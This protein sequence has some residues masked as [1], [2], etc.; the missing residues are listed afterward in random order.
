MTMAGSS[1]R[2]V[3]APRHLLKKSQIA[4][5]EETAFQHRLN[6]NALRHT[7]SLGRA[8]GMTRLGVHLVRLEP[9]RDST[10]YHFHHHE[11][12]FVYI[13]SGRGE[14]DIGEETHPVEAGDFMGFSAPSLPHIMRNPHDEDLVYL[15]GGQS[16]AD[17]VTE[18]PRIG[19]IMYKV[20]GE[21]QVVDGKHIERI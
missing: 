18:Y 7:K 5:M 1:D 13:L 9:G 21:R 15:M 10:E 4:K 12:E 20:R 19:K 16:L 2:D 14:T 3:P 17:D 8:T 6:K 11:E